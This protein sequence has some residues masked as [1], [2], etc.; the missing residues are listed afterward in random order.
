MFVRVEE[1]NI[2]FDAN[3]DIANNIPVVYIHGAGKT[4]LVWKNQMKISIPGYVQI[5]PDLPGHGKSEGKGYNS[6]DDYTDFV[7]KFL[8]SL[9]K[10]KMIL[11]G[12]SMGGAITINFALKYPEFLKGIILIGTGAKLRVKDEI[13][14]E[15]KSGKSYSEKAYSKKTPKA[16]IDIAE[17]DFSET[18]PIVRYNDFFACNNFDKME[19]ISKIDIKTLVICGM[20]DELTPLK[21]SKYL[22]DNIKG[23]ILKTIP[24]AGHMVMWEKFD[25][26]NSAIIEFINELT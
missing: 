5:A 19:D 3:G 7:L 25:E 2:Y 18:E 13:L 20:D 21:Y 10:E 8:K 4:H 15:A 1:Q 24:D 26:V 16:I 17:K 12:Q 23:S 14:Q 11:A 9:N 22:H 6:I